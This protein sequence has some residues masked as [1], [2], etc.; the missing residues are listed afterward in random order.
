MLDRDLAA[1]ALRPLG[2]PT[3]NAFNDARKTFGKN[4]EATKTTRDRFTSQI[5]GLVD[6]VGYWAVF[7]T[8]LVEEYEQVP[9][10]VRLDSH[11]LA[12]F[13][14]IGS[15]TVRLKSDT[16]NLPL[17]QLTI[18]GVDTRA[19][20]GS[21]ERVILT[22]DHNHS[23][24]YAPAFVQLDGK[25]EAWRLPI[26]ALLAEPVATVATER[27]KPIVTS[28]RPG[29]ARGDVTAPGQS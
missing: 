17:D 2:E 26:T 20:D 5:G 13:W 15:I 11:P 18:P 16:G 8:N 12:H 1:E 24:R 7:A 22:W 14:T 4:C 6:G 10:V 28:N 29:I 21:P 27:R 25:R 23:E 19:T 3:M 9:G